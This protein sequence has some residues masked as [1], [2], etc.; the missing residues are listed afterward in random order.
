MFL[1][2]PGALFLARRSRLFVGYKLSSSTVETLTHPSFAICVF[3]RYK[4]Y[5]GTAVSVLRR[6]TNRED[7][8]IKA[9][10]ARLFLL[11]MGAITASAMAQN[12]NQRSNQTQGQHSNQPANQP[13]PIPL[14]AKGAPGA[15]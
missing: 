1:T 10:N 4:A 3:R 7:K 14:W 15:K 2:S 6:Q 8:M 13:A 9:T 5:C 11:L 12:P